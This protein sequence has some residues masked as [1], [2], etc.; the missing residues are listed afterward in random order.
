LL[1]LEK[2]DYCGGFSFKT[3][4]CPYCGRK[5]CYYHRSPEKHKCDWA[6]LLASEDNRRRM[7]KDLIH[8]FLT[9]VYNEGIADF[10]RLSEVFSKLNSL[11]DELWYSRNER[12]LIKA[13]LKLIDLY[14]LI[15][16]EL[17]EKYR[18]FLCAC[19]N[20]V[21]EELG[22]NLKLLEKIKMHSVV[23]KLVDENGS[24]IEGCFAFFQKEDVVIDGGLS[25]KHGII[26]IELPQGV[27]DV[28]IYKGEE[29]WY[30]CYTGKVN[31][32]ENLEK[33]NKP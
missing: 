32:V 24:P 7:F 20:F 18:A 30:F 12:E 25:N 11:R 28:L 16:N 5:F 8:S 10:Q 1:K 6:Y 22:I 17:R 21:L 15:P 4:R 3:Y 31:V 27:Y 23:L 26:H 29:K 9:K 19:E 33:K 2:C 13:L 14:I